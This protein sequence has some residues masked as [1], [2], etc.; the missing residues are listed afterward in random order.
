MLNLHPQHFCDIDLN[1]L[2]SVYLRIGAIVIFLQAGEVRTQWLKSP[3]CSS[4]EPGFNS[5]NPHGSSQPSV[6]PVPR[7]PKPS[8]KHTCRQNTNAHKIKMNTLLKEKKYFYCF[9][10][11]IF[12]DW[13]SSHGIT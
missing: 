5:Q 11:K 12:T 6:T 13:N 7:D 8:H 10:V 9:L 3:S 4:E 2:L 1:Y